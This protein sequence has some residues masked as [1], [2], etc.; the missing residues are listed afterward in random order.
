MSAIIQ[1]VSKSGRLSHRREFHF[2][3]A[4]RGS[5]CGLS[6][7][8][9]VEMILIPG[10]AWH[11]QMLWSSCCITISRKVNKYKRYTVSWSL[12]QI[13]PV[14][15]CK[16]AVRYYCSFCAMKFYDLFLFAFSLQILISAIL[17]FVIGSLWYPKSKIWVARLKRNVKSFSYLHVSLY[18][19]KKFLL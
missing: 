15:M 2:K 18:W 19:K 6:G 10:V 3:P 14:L 16:H 12:M 5:I 7:L 4:V 13:V 1:R 9:L 11:D 8:L 17:Q